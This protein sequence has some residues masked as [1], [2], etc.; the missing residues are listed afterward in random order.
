MRREIGPAR[1]AVD[2]IGSVVPQTRVRRVAPLA[3]PAVLTS[4]HGDQILVPR[5]LTVRTARLHMVRLILPRRALR[6]R[7]GRGAGH[8]ELAAGARQARRNMFGSE[9]RLSVRLL[10]GH[11]KAVRARLAAC[12]EQNILVL[13]K[14]TR[15]ARQ[16][17]CRIVLAYIPISIVPG[18]L[19]CRGRAGLPTRIMRTD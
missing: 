17:H 8:R 16:S 14:R 6:T 3:D 12:R 7:Q 1:R 13:A 10:G 11:V 4:S 9:V 18:A 19:E 2:A 5:D 15:N